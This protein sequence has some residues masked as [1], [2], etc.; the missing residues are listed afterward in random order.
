MEMYQKYL[1]AF[2]DLYKAVGW[3]IQLGPKCLLTE[4][5]N[6]SYNIIFEDLKE[7]NFK[8]IDRLDGCDMVHMQHILR[9]LAELH[10]VSAVY[11]EI[12]GQYPNDFQKGF[13]NLEGGAE[14]QQ[15]M[16]KTRMGQYKKAMEQW[17]L[18]AAGKYIKNFVSK[19]IL[20]LKY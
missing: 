9:K 12:H 14:F 11:K 18:N 7:K 15:N 6:K 8:N 19:K 13:V 3:H 1:P 2:E 16:F 5:K 4:K 17:G 10:A 20:I